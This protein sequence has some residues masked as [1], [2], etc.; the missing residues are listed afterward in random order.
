MMYQS[1]PAD[2]ARKAL[3]TIPAQLAV[4]DA[5]TVSEL[6]AKWQ[7]VFGD[8]PAGRNREHLCKRI[9]WRIQE[10]A[11]G[12]LSEPA[13]QQIGKLNQGDLP[14]LGARPKP[15][16]AP[17]PEPQPPDPTRDP[18]LP[19]PG[20]VLR[21]LHKGVEHEVRVLDKGFEYAGKHYRSLSG[22]AKAITGAHWN[23]PLFFNL[24]GAPQ[25]Q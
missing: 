15:A 7:E 1:T 18:R 2:A 25:E 10:L 21:K 23:G 4:L 17:D 22:V 5:M 13:E 16:P 14:V 19:P 20:G 6:Q 24:G 9:A 8:P 3:G 12:G 11:E